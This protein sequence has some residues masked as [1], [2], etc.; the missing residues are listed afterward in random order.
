M[1]TATAIAVEALVVVVAGSLLALA[2]NGLS[3]R[4][5]RL[6]RNYFPGDK[7]AAAAPM[8]STTPGVSG[9]NSTPSNT[10]PAP[11]GESSASAVTDA[12]RR[13]LEQRG[14][15][16]IALNQ[17]TNL[18]RDPR[19]EQGLIVFIDARDDSHYQAGH[20]PGA[21]QFYHYQ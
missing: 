21:W 12:A 11:A 13:R 18:F 4:G 17:V 10:A 19:T 7:P 20:I 9:S 14:L 2:A 16:A 5:L 6:G 15:Q 3:P 1:R 8:A